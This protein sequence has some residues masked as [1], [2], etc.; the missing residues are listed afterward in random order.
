MHTSATELCPDDR[1]RNPG[2]TGAI[3]L[4]AS[5]RVLFIDRNVFGLLGAL[6]S[7]WLAPTE[8]PLLPSC[9][10]T[11]LREFAAHSTSDRRPGSLS[12]R[13][14]QCFG[15]RS[16]PILVQGFVVSHHEQRDRKFV[17]VLSRSNPS[18]TV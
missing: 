9:L 5:C 15:P 18:T 8:A 7:D 11:M 6:D 16:H 4:S 12:A 14:S 17:L 1:T 13:R 10:M 3:V 2:S